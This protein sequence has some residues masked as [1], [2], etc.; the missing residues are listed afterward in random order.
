M[1]LSLPVH[2]IPVNRFD[3]EGLLDEL[4]RRGV[5]PGSR[6]LLPRSEQARETLPQGLRARGC[7]VDTVTAYRN[8]APDIDTDALRR[9]L[10]TSELDALTFTSPST[11]ANFAAMLDDAARAGAARCAIAAIGQVTADALRKNGLPPDVVPEAPGA[12]S[13]VTAL[14]EYFAAQGLSSTEGET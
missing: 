12:E 4:E 1:R 11:V 9:Q 5:P 13:L 3:A 7:V 6:V 10:A 8:V 2:G 14:I